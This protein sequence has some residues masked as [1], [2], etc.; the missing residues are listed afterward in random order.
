MESP[1]TALAEPARRRLLDELL[2]GPLPVG[3]LAAATGMSQPNTS[4]HLRVLREAELVQARRQGQ[5]RV[6]SL[7]AHG[8][9]RLDEW[10]APYARLWGE[11]LDALERHLDNE[12]RE[13]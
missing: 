8:F 13:P 6:Y 1:F 9:G 11:R 12:E 2:A 10:L 3:E 4:R 5:L 7:R